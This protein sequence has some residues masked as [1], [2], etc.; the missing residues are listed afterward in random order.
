[1]VHSIV[2]SHADLIGANL[3]SPSSQEAR[4]LGRSAMR[5]NLSCADTVMFDGAASKSLPVL[6]V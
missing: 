4:Q 6:H 2:S 3:A 5:S 1:M